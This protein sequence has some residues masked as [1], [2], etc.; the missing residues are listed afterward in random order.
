M[1]VNGLRPSV[2]LRT[3]GV[4][5][6]SEARNLPPMTSSGSTSAFYL[7]AG[8]LVLSFGVLGSSALMSPNGPPVP[9]VLPASALLPTA[10]LLLL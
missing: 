9:A 5:S 8:T 1:E 7:G 6:P 3:F 4:R 10:S 2:A